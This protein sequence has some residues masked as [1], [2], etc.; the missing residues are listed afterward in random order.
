MLFYVVLCFCFKTITLLFVFHVLKALQYRVEN[1][2]LFLVFI[3]FVLECTDFIR[4]A[5]LSFFVSIIRGPCEDTAF[6][7]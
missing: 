3:L 1:Y 2:F 4:F 7:L 6:Y 5:F